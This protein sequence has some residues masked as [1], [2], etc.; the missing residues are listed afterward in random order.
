MTQ[1]EF[2]ETIN[3]L[4]AEINTIHT[5]VANLGTVSIEQGGKIDSN[6]G[7]ISTVE[8]QQ[9]GRKSI[10]LLAAFLVNIHVQY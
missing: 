4:V 8:T 2:T 1:A 7:R 10:D 6:S 9:A 5:D 3:L